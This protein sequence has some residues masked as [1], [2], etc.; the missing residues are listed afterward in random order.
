MQGK[1]ILGNGIL[2]NGLPLENN[3]LRIPPTRFQIRT[4]HILE[5]RIQGNRILGKGILGN[6]VSLETIVLITR[7][8]DS[9]SGHTT[10]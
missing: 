4:H 1:H 9:K 2:G 7:T 8:T 5:G 10:F 3:V 6:R